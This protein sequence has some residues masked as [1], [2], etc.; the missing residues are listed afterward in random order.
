MFNI[1][2]LGD[3]VTRAR[4]A[5]RANLPGSDAWLWPNNINPTA[6]VLGGLTS[7][8]FGFADSIQQAKFALT[9]VGPDLDRHGQELAPPVIRFEPRPSAG[10]IVITVADAFAVAFGAVFQRSDGVQFSATAPAAI[11][12]AGTLNVPAQSV[13]TGS[14]TVTIAGTALSIVSG[15]T[16]VNGDAN[17]TAAVGS[18]GLIGGADTELDG[19]KYNPP[20]GTYRYRVLFRKRNPP[21][22][23]AAADYV[24]W[25]QAANPNVTRVFVERLW[26]GSGTVRVFPLMDN[27]YADG[28]PQSADIAQIS[29]F[30]STVQ[31]SGA[32][33]T[34]A[35][36]AAVPT[37]VTVSGLTPNNAA[38]QSAVQT[39]LAA[40]LL[41]LGAVAGTDTFNPAMPYLAVPFSF[42]Q[43]WLQ[44]AVD[45]A[46]G[47]TRGLVTAPAAGADIALADGQMATLGAVSFT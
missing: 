32:V 14:A 30:L 24:V 40:A 28:I 43:Q 33:V 19:A 44:Q 23:G 7:E 26:A 18:G 38:T 4:A 5:F 34:T 46:T 20:P 25:C 41:R 39:E 22:G 10:T 11:A 35:A 12:T 6:K 37:N 17:A 45:N 47:V 2:T 29:A 36:A 31:P 3:L 9:A 15:I 8:L 13:G 16:D 42:A 27:L 21:M 1:P